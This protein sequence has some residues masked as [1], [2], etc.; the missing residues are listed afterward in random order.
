MPIWHPSDGSSN[1]LAWPTLITVTKTQTEPLEKRFHHNLFPKSVWTPLPLSM[2]ESIHL[3]PLKHPFYQNFEWGFLSLCI[4]RDWHW[5]SSCPESYAFVSHDS[6]GSL[7]TWRHK[8]W[9]MVTTCV[10][11]DSGGSSL[12]YDSFTIRITFHHDSC[13]YCTIMTRL[14]HFPGCGLLSN[15][16]YDLYGTGLTIYKDSQLRDLL[17]KLLLKLVS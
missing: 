16:I 4:W 5:L 14:G 6:H 1:P 17:L 13:Y 7:V 9:Q 2:H 10:G 12:L 8:A 15:S 3:L 11:H